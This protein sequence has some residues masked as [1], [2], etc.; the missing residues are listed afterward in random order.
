[1]IRDKVKQFFFGLTKNIEGLLT[2]S[3][4][5]KAQVNKLSVTGKHKND[6]LD[7]KSIASAFS[8]DQKADF[9][10][11]KTIISN[12]KTLDQLSKGCGPREVDFAEGLK[13]M[14]ETFSQGKVEDAEYAKVFA[15]K[16]KDTLNAKEELHKAIE[17]ALSSIGTIKATGKVKGVDK[18][19]WENA[20]IYG[21]FVHSKVLIATN[22]DKLKKKHTEELAE[23]NKK[24]F[25]R[26]GGISEEE[27]SRRSELANQNKE[28]SFKATVKF[29]E[30][31]GRSSDKIKALARNEMLEIL[32]LS[33]EVLTIMESAEKSGKIAEKVSDVLEKSTEEVLKTIKAT[34]DTS[35]MVSVAIREAQN[36][37]KEC[38]AAVKAISSDSSSLMLEVVKRS[39]DYVRASINNWETK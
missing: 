21:P 34:P 28:A 5:L 26:I 7:N 15:E 17:G 30:L 1:M 22:A 12:V 18:S 31:D 32:K 2:Q 24:Y 27:K 8:V 14:A 9:S 37:T 29:E 38:N 25:D 33:D 19:V 23:L 39:H 13:K 16:I 20:D 6:D 36:S 35:A 3:S 11:A 10:T 4:D